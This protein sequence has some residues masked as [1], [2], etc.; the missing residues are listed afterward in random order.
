MRIRKLF[1][2]YLL[3][4][5]ALLF[6]NRKRS[7]TIHRLDRLY[8]NRDSSIIKKDRRKFCLNFQRL[9]FDSKGIFL[10]SDSGEFIPINNLSYSNGLYEMLRPEYWKCSNCRKVN[11]NNHFICRRCEFPKKFE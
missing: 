2:F 8:M 6:T 3:G 7:S 1:L 5:N 9:V 10:E 4:P 11:K